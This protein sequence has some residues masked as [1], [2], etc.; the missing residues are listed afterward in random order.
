VLGSSPTIDASAVTTYQR[1]ASGILK[2]WFGAGGPLRKT[3]VFSAETA[4][5]SAGGAAELVL[6]QRDA[7][8]GQASP[9]GVRAFRVTFTP[10]SDAKTRVDME[11]MKV[12]ADLAAA[13]E[14]D[15]LAYAFEKESC[16]VQVVRPPPPQPEPV[17]K[18]RKK[19]A[20]AV[21]R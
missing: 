2:C 14:T 3:H 7:M 1:V 21:K 10:V 6:Y 17:A 12:A 16:K 18:T 20:P 4:P 8:P 9:R 19:P 11:A 15:V 5:P 13:M